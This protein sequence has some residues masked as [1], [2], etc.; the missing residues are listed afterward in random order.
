MAHAQRTAP[1]QFPSEAP[2]MTRFSGSNSVSTPR[3][4]AEGKAAFR[5]LL[6]PLYHQLNDAYAICREAYDKQRDQATSYCC[7]GIRNVLKFLKHVSYVPSFVAV[8]DCLGFRND[9][10]R[11]GM[12]EDWYTFI[13]NVERRAVALIHQAN[14]IKARMESP[15]S[16]S[17]TAEP[18][19]GERPA[20]PI[21]QPTVRVQNPIAKTSMPVQKPHTA[22]HRPEIHPAIPAAGRKTVGRR[23]S[24]FVPGDGMEVIDLEDDE[25]GRRADQRQRVQNA[26]RFQLTPRLGNDQHSQRA[27]E[28]KTTVSDISRKRNVAHRDNAL[29]QENTTSPRR[30]KID[31]SGRE[32][33]IQTG[34]QTPKITLTVPNDDLHVGHKGEKQKQD[35]TV[36][37]QAFLCD[38]KGVLQ[39]IGENFVEDAL[40]TLAEIDDLLHQLDASN[41]VGACSNAMLRDLALEE[42][43][44][45]YDRRL[46]EALATKAMTTASSQV[47]QSTTR[48]TFHHNVPITGNAFWQL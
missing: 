47:S 11:D 28:R 33:I 5:K 35:L 9:K 7:E 12:T 44:W 30:R 38:E 16:I 4:E 27:H 17:S 48:M 23:L 40:P 19:L 15:H 13:P 24:S 22:P 36:S 25:P 21:V 32:M 43:D 42:D 26:N 18:P 45:N 8:G 2:T 29:L 3:N 34:V 39:C 46:L 20:A 6:A 31:P 37:D 41:G 14:E 1:S 10:Q